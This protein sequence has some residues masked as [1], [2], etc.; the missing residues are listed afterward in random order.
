MIFHI[1]YVCTVDGGFDEV[2]TID[3]R[4]VPLGG[5]VGAIIDHTK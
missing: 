1:E 4:C 3:D 2:L 5:I